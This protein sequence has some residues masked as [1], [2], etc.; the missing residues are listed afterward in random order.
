MTVAIIAGM[1]RSGTS[2]ITRMLNL[3]GLYLGE[4]KDLIPPAPDNPEGFWENRQFVLL[5]DEILAK[6]GGAWDYSPT[7]Q[8]GWET[9]PEMLPLRMRA[10]QV[11][12]QFADHENWAWKDPRNSYTFPFW[13]TLVPDLK[14]LVC[15]RNPLEV[16]RSLSKRNLSS[17]TMGYNLWARYN[18][19]ILSYISPEHL[20][21]THYDSYFEN[22]RAELKRVLNYLRV[23]ASDEQ[24]ER[25]VNTISGPIRRNKAINLNADEQPSEEV[26][27]LYESLCTYAGPVF[28][29]I[30]PNDPL[31]SPSYAQYQTEYLLNAEKDKLLSKL[32]EKDIV[33]SEKNVIISEK[34]E[35]IR[36]LTLEASQ[37]MNSQTWRYAQR[38]TAYREKLFPYESLRGR[39]LRLVF[40]GLRTWRKEGLRALFY[41]IYRK[42]QKLRASETQIATVL[43]MEQ[44]FISIVIP[45]FNA[46]QM[47]KNCIKKIYGIST[48]FSFEVIVVDNH[49]TDETEQFLQAEQKRLAHFRSYRMVENLGFAGAVNYGIRQARGNYVVIL[50]NDTLV[51]PGWLDGLIEAF[52]KDEMIGIV[53]PVT[54][55]VG[56]GPQID[57]E[58]ARIEPIDIDAYAAKIKNRD[59]AYESNRLV[60]FCVAIKR[61]VL[62]VVGDLDIR[63][64]KGNYEDD[65]YCMRTISSGFRLAISQSSFV[66]HFGSITFKDNKISHTENMERNRKRFY[67]RVQNISTT[68]RPARKRDSK[69]NVSVIVRTQNRPDLLKRALASLSNQT[70]DGFNVVVVN[71]GGEDISNI[72]GQFEKYFPV[73]YIHK[74]VQQGRSAALNTGIENS[75]GAWVAFLDDDDIVYPWH[76]DALMNGAKSNSDVYF[77]YGNYNVSL[78]TTKQDTFSLVTAGVEPWN[79]DPLKLLVRNYLPIHTWLIA[80]ECFE[81]KGC[82]LNDQSMLEDYEFIL[83]ISRSFGFYHINRVTCEYRYYLDGVNSM[84]TQRPKTLESLKFIY[85][86]NLVENP[87]ILA[88]RNLELVKLEEQIKKIQALQHELDINPDQKPF[89]YRQIINLVAG[90]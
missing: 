5:N 15:L 10:A 80:R 54:N 76:L 77:F 51:T 43:E 3:C 28:Q 26:V 88:E 86:Q 62:D 68:L 55:Y 79:Y 2:M 71:D 30:L 82:F 35:K 72:I 85:A 38:I 84:V 83:R 47:T 22:P 90:I 13:R 60:F 11:I 14:I 45:V 75:H 69:T 66:Y 59:F 57:P 61:E 40:K 19:Q 63:Y 81:K 44:P 58:A 78:F 29:S 87:N 1:H 73:S 64:E 56:E 31:L 49:S 42:A 18:Q 12:Q 8:S 48:K 33:I 17:P 25:A 41:G 7:L 65:D 24:F 50:N 6:L 46:V 36:L 39:S 32:V 34:E 27:R 23:S 67:Q 37:M 21:I 53:S 9:R 52:N 16:V 74:T 4:E 70:F 20:L 89:I